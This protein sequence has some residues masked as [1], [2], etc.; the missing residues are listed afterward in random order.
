MIDTS[1]YYKKT[2]SKSWKKKF[3]FNQDFWKFHRFVIL[4][5]VVS[6]G[7]MKQREFGKFLENDLEMPLNCKFNA[8]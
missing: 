5:I 7:K 4:K 2:W 1:M 3:N 6:G 8:G